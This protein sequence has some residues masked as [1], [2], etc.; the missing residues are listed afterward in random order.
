MVR[1]AD[2][3]VPVR[4]K[5]DTGYLEGNPNVKRGMV[6][7]VELQ[8]TLRYYRLG[9]AQPAEV[10]PLGEAYKPYISR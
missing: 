3:R 7:D 9:Y 1:R 4:V 5:I 6:V 2:G 8:D 10:E